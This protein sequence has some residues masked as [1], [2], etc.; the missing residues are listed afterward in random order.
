MI[1][2]VML[3]K[4]IYSLVDLF[5]WSAVELHELCNLAGSGQRQSE[6]DKKYRYLCYMFVLRTR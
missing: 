4:N 2:I 5:Y 3:W 6:I 1:G